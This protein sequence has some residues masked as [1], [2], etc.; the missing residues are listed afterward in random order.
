MKYFHKIHH[1]LDSSALQHG[2][3][4]VRFAWLNFIEHKNVIRIKERIVGWKKK[5]ITASICY[6]LHCGEIE[7][8]RVNNAS[9]NN[10]FSVGL[11]I[12]LLHLHLQSNWFCCHLENAQLMLRLKQG[13]CMVISC[14]Q[15]A[16][17]MAN[18]K[19]DIVSSSFSIASVRPL[20]FSILLVLSKYLTVFCNCFRRHPIL[21]KRHRKRRD[22]L[23]INCG[24]II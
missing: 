4:N 10:S 9:F 19:I 6:Q 18:N 22:K 14:N 16:L 8:R 3:Q 24:V 15:I 11:V 5:N 20:F 1:H 17:F 13:N 12:P 23:G 2:L 7:R 21:L